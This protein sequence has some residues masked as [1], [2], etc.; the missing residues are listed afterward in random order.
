MKMRKIIIAALVALSMNVAKAEDNE[1]AKYC[2]TVFVTFNSIPPNRED[3]S[4]IM[5]PVI[6]LAASNKIYSYQHEKS[7][8]ASSCLQVLKAKDPA[9]FDDPG[10]TPEV[11]HILFLVGKYKYGL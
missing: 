5:S 2:T 3:V 10:F 6:R 7:Q 11:M 9:T 4:A 1:L 8:Y